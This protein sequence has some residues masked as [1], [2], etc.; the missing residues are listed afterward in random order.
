M[1]DITEER[2]DRAQLILVAAIVLAV[3][4]IGLAIVVNSAIFSENLATRGDVPGSDEALDFQY[5]V[6]QNVGELV[7]SI[8]ENES[9]AK[10]DI[11]GAVESFQLQSAIQQ[12][13]RGGTVNV[14]YLSDT[15][16]QR[17]AQEESGP[18]QNEMGNLTVAE[19]VDDARNIQFDFENID[20]E[21]DF[22]AKDSEQKNWTMTVDEDRIMVEIATDGNFRSDTCDVDASDGLTIDVTRATVDGDRCQA[23]ERTGEGESLWFAANIENDYTIEFEGGDSVEGTYSMI[24]QQDANP[25]PDPD[26][27]PVDDLSAIVDDDI[28]YS[29]EIQ[30]EY[31][32]H[33]VQSKTVIRVAP[34][35]VPP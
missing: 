19:N 34:G 25:F 27:D 5:E 24:L 1:A 12:S 4:F 14:Q 21:F 9:Y 33:A 28:A 17:V 30:Y 11:E 20:G 23:L 8:N 18:L 13:R 7:E 22:I 35:E 3:T 2:S 31:R 16:G 26:L 15:D 32:T 10:E 6:N 29:V